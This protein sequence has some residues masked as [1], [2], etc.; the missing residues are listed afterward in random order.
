[1][2]LKEFSISQDIKALQYHLLWGEP[3]TGSALE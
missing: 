3:A 2:V 1:M